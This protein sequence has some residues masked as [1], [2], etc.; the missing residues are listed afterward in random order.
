MSEVINYA[1]HE[2]EGIKII[3]AS[4][5]LTRNTYKNF[6]AIIQRVLDKDSVMIDLS[7]IKIITSSGLETIADLSWEAKQSEKRLVIL[8]PSE[9]LIHLADTMGLI[10]YLTLASSYEEGLTKIS[11]FT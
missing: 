2:Y 1:I 8:W 3:E 11:Y 6:S 7:Q 10:D 4:G 5:N 9:D